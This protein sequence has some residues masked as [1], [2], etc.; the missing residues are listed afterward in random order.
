[1]TNNPTFDTTLYL[2][3]LEMMML[4]NMLEMTSVSWGGIHDYMANAEDKGE[5]IFVMWRVAVCCSVLQSVAASL[6]VAS[7]PI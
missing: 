1:L 6:G 5:V 4:P 2:S 3:D 7:M